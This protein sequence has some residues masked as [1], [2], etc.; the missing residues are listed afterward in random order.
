MRLDLSQQLRLDQRMKLAP[1]MIQSMEILQLP[2]LALQERI[3]QELVSNPV[4]EVLDP[5]DEQSTAELDNT[6]STDSEGERGLV[7]KDDA[8]QVEDFER[9]ENYSSERDWD[10]YVERSNRVSSKSHA[11]ER[12]KKMDAMANTAARPESLNEHLLAQWALIEAEP[13]IKQ[14]GEFIISQIDKDGYLRTPLEK[15][16]D[17]TRL[18]LSEQLLS[19]ALALLQQRLEPVGV[20]ARDLREC[21]LLQMDISGGSNDIARILVEHHLKQIESNRLPAIAK[22]ANLTID[23]INEGIAVIR[24]LNPKPGLQIGSPEV[25][26]VLPDVFIEYEPDTDEYSI[27][28]SDENTPSLYIGRTYLSMMKDRSV[29]TQTRKFIKNN[30]R[31]ANWLIEAIE[32]RKHTL[33]RVVEQVVAAQRDF[34]DHGP[35]HLKPLRMIHLAARIGVHVSTVARAVADK[36]VQTPRGI[37]PL[38]RFFSGGTEDAD[39]QSTSWDAVKAKLKE[40]IDVEDKHNPLN[41]DQIVMKMKEQGIDLARRT[42]AKYRSMLNIPPARRRRQY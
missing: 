12:D 14:A 39:G 4:L 35:Q 34:L 21:L 16:G 32:Q 25:P 31:S 3:E 9:L 15:L 40:V 20:G 13:I 1:R 22:K 11:G 38:R 10:E 8:T 7:V 2:L 28:L 17:F 27:R 37:Y 5:V 41:D 26:Y 30:V 23:D 42:V 19:E 33:R 36:Y 18:Q 24:R 6:A 29:D